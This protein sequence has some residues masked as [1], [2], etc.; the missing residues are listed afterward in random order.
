MG[1]G[2]ERKTIVPGVPPFIV[3]EPSKA[4]TLVSSAGPDAIYASVP[5]P[6]TPADQLV[7][8]ANQSPVPVHVVVA[9]PAFGA[10]HSQP[11]VAQSSAIGVL[12]CS[13]PMAARMPERDGESKV[14]QPEAGGRGATGQK[15]RPRENRT[16]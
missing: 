8:S 4:V 16:R 6:G 13:L 3:N 15:C 11:S 9:A 14:G 12:W 5:P 10:G 7:A 1:G 2:I